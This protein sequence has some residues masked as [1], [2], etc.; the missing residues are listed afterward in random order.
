MK[1]FT[2]TELA[3]H[4]TEDHAL[5]AI[6]GKAWSLF[7]VYELTDFLDAH[8]GGKRVILPFLGKDA[9]SEFKL[10]HAAGIVTHRFKHLVI[11]TLAG[12][13]A[14]HVV[15][16]SSDPF[17]NLIAFAEP[18][19]Y[20]G[21][22]SPFYNDS[23]KRLRSWIRNLVET[24]IMPF[25]GDWDAAGEVPRSVY[26]TFGKAGVLS[27]MPGAP[28]SPLSP[29]APPCGIEPAE[30][31]LFHEMIV[32]DEIARCGSSGVG[33]AL[34]LGPQIALPAVIHFASE[35]I[36]RR[37]VAP[38]LL[39]EKTI[40]LAI[41]EPYAGSDVAGIQTTATL[42]VDGSHFVVSGEK[43]WIT[44]GTWADF[45]VVAAKTGKG[46]TLFLLERGMEGLR[47]RSIKCQGNS[48]S[49]T[50]FVILEN[51]KVGHKDIIG[52]LDNGFKCIMRNFNHE[53][54]G[55]IV[56]ALRSA[57]ICYEDA[58]TFAHRRKTFGKILFDHGVIRQKLAHMA[59]QIEAAHSWMESIAYQHS[60]LSHE[61]AMVALGGPIALLKAQIT[62]TVEFCAR[63]ASQI[64]GGLSYTRSAGGVGARI[65]RVYRDVRGYAIPGGSEEIMLDLGMRQAQKVSIARGAKF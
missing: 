23:H 14:S 33:F 49:G 32:L 40:C 39:G 52:Q 17:G 15:P 46:V 59:R 65:E 38:V 25:V 34:T 9:S 42:A 53:R 10:Y 45:F 61:E 57:R 44:N 28:W 18:A 51:V 58:M 5:I 50:A 13:P 12:N 27:C 48:G 31:T 60:K 11:G 3:S 20:S 4:N 47:T 2:A 19:W 54:F 64:L 36:K 6:D 16:S 1:T 29:H 21:Q 55:I 8:P 22:P 56:A 30:W 43:K 7:L 37:V 63:E 41:T 62:Q 26:E 24:H 35:E